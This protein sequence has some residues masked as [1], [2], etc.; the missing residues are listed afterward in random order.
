MCN[1]FIFLSK[2]YDKLQNGITNLLDLRNGWDK[3]RI[4]AQQTTIGFMGGPRG[5]SSDNQI[6]GFFKKSS[7]FL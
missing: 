4:V 7:D 1:I 6:I 5:I 3:N 2:I